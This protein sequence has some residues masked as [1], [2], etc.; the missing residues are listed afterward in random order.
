MSP[1][2]KALGIEAASFVS[3]TGNGI[4]GRGIGFGGETWERGK[5]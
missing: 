1:S 4:R 5:F 3:G 2:P